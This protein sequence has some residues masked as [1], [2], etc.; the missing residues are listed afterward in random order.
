[1]SNNP[2]QNP[3]PGPEP[4]TNTPGYGA[5]P[6]YGAVPGYYG[7]QPGSYAGLRAIQPEHPQAVTILILGILSLFFC[8]LLGPIA[9]Y[10]GSKAREDVK[11]S[12]VGYS[13]ANMIS[14][15]WV[16]GIVAT[17]VM[18]FS[19]LVMIGFVVLLLLIPAS[20]A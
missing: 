18:I 15:G 10:M 20:G 6:G 12:D 14:I 17:C 5:A 13:N 19:V 7:A 16:F 3:Y 4:Y 8:Q 2:N 9:W 11:A 1:M